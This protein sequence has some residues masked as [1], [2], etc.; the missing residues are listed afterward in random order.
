MRVLGIDPGTMVTGWA[1]V[2]CDNRDPLRL[3]SGTIRVGR[4]EIAGRLAAIYSRLSELISGYNPDVLSLER[5]F[6]AA[7]VQSAF[8]LGEARGVAMAAAA[9]SSVALCEYSPATIKKS[10]VGYGR[11]DKLQVQ[12]AVS[13]I[14]RLTAPPDEDEADALAAAACHAFHRSYETRLARAL[15]SSNGRARA[16]RLT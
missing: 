1:I 14:F 10:V 8:R 2:E 9:A 13:R 7:N 5:H 15:E 16:R 4:G 11:A 3:A 6:V 12:S